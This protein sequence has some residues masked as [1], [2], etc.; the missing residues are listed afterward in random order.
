[1]LIH[2]PGHTDKVMAHSPRNITQCEMAIKGVEC[3]AKVTKKATVSVCCYCVGDAKYLA[4][5]MGNHV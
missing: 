5:I 1:M 4:E 3:L 2:L